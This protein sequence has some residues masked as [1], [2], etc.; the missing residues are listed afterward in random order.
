MNPAVLH[1]LPVG[2]RGKTYGLSDALTVFLIAHSDRRSLKAR[3][4]VEP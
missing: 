2:A 4:T 3:L 1:A